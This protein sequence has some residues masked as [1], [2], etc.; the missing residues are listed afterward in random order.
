[1]SDFRC[2]YDE[3][4]D[5]YFNNCEESCIRYKEMS[6]LISNSNIPE[7]R[8]FPQTLSA[9]RCD[10]DAFCRLSELKSTIDEF[11]DCGKNLYITSE[12]T[13]NGKTTWA[14]KLMLKYFDIIWAGN[15]FT[16]RGL[17]IHVPTFL[18]KCKDFN[19]RDL[20]FEHIKEILPTVDLV[21]WDDIASTELS[22]YDYSQLLMYLDMRISNNKSNIFTGNITS[23]DTMQKALASKLTSRIWSNSTE[24]ITFR[25]GDRR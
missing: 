15:G 24:I 17:F 22:A 25:G 6:Y 5:L 21:I 8:Q 16:E 10:Y 23:R 19:N 7:S 3:V 9:P 12:S 14:I 1:M 4:C 18:L 20:T 13:G 2:W 11:V